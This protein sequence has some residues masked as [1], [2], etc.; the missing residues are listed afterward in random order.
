MKKV[1]KKVVALAAVT[2]MSMTALMGCA[3]SIDNSEVVATVGEKEITAGLANF[4]TR[5]QQASVESYYEAML[6]EN[7]WSMEIQDGYT[8]GDSIKETIMGTL[9]EMY[10]LDAHAEE[11]KVAL[12][13]DE[14]AKIE[15]AVAAFEEANDEKTKKLISGET[16]Y[17]T[18][19]LRLTTLSEKVSAAMVADV[20]TKVSD[21][22][23]AQKKVRYVS[24]EKVSTDDSGAE[25]EMTADEI[26][27]VKKEAEDFLAAAKANGSLENY[28][29][30]KDVDALT[31]S[32][33]SKSTTI[34]ENFI[35]TVDALGEGEFAAVIEEEDA[36]YV[37]QL[38]SLLDREATDAK[39]E[40]IVSTR[41][42]EKYSEL[43]EDW[44]EATEI[45]VND[46]VWDKI[47]LRALDMT[48]KT[49]EEDTTAE[50]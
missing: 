4:Y 30:G 40:S 28:A 44:Y 36:F 47:E 48:V 17:I 46:K 24:F 37:A 18:E 15:A 43:V 34:S 38:E 41:Q 12:T 19:M 13:D 45:V 6:G 9:Q 1:M 49:I 29:K 16:E 32:F 20:D 26:A 25:V 14:M 33:D 3:S 27:A 31:V 50:E 21:D 2:A 10:L 42:N 11:Y 5:Y 7:I 8:Y 22:E 23:A 39:K 35:K